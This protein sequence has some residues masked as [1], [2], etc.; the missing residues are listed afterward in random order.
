MVWFSLS[1][2]CSRAGAKTVEKETPQKG[3][4]LEMQSVHWLDYLESICGD[5]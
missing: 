1:R 5:C 2:V 4:A 3:V